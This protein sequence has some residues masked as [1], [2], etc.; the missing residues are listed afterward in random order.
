[1]CIAADSGIDHARALGI[2]PDLAVGDFDSVTA[3]GLE[4][5]SRSGATVTRHPA[6]KNHTDL[7]LAIDAALATDPERVVVIAVAG[8]RTDH[9]LANIAVLAQPAYRGAEIDAYM[10][11]SVISVVHDRRTLA[12]EA[13]ETITLLPVGGDAT[14][15]TTDGL[16]YPLVGEPLPAGT[17]RG[18]SNVFDG[19]SAT[20]SVES[21]VLLA[22]RPDHLRSERL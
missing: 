19:E 9:F 7:E 2:I 14:G 11:T 22:I 3:E 4:W 17:T 6:A 5:V 15:V 10:G 21:G 16:R 20:V 12:G 13:G 18:V 1:M 8:G